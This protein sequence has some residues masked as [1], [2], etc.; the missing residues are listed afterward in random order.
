MESSV[1]MMRSLPPVDVVVPTATGV[2]S[3]RPAVTRIDVSATGDGNRVMVIHLPQG[4]EPVRVDMT[5]A[6]AEHLAM[7]LAP[8][9][10][11]S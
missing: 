4:E 7:L 1:D 3:W 8:R 10:I 11:A 6:V 5:A 9:S 2:Q